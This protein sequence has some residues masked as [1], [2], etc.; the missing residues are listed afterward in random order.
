MPVGDEV[1]ERQHHLGAGPRPVGLDG[2]QLGAPRPGQRVEDRQV[3]VAGGHVL[4]DDAEGVALGRLPQV[5]DQPQPQS[6]QPFEV[7]VHAI[8]QA[9][10]SASARLKVSLGRMIESAYERSIR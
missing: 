5:D 4:G 9:E 7:H 6:T 2:E 1:E 8:D 3:R 10:N